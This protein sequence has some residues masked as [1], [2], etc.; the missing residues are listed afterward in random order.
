MNRRHAKVN[1]PVLILLGQIDY[2]TPHHPLSSFPLAISLDV[3]EG[4]IL[5]DTSR[6]SQSHFQT[7][8]RTE[9]KPL[10]LDLAEITLK[11]VRRWN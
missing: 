4:E 6:S 2:C 8:S 3:Q 11:A 10:G 5:S 7:L 1:P 9:S